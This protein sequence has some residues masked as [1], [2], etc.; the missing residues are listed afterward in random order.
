MRIIETYRPDLAMSLNEVIFPEDEFDFSVNDRFW[1][2]YEKGLPVGFASVRPLD[3]CIVYFNRAG[4]LE[5]ARGKGLHIRLIE[6]RLRWSRQHGFAC[7][8]TYTV[9]NPQSYSNLQ[10]KGFRLYSPECK[11]VGDVLYWIKYLN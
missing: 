9:D 7:A 3:N 1:I 8:I 11:Y 5:E 10:K 4:L 6:R 2:A